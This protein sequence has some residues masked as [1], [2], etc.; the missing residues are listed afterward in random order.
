MYLN[1]ELVHNRKTELEVYWD[2]SILAEIKVKNTNFLIGLFYSPN[3]TTQT[4]ST[5]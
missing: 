3:R 5:P 2:E 4:F 1:S